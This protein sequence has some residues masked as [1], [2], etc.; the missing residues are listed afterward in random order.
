VLL[1]WRRDPHP[2]HRATWGPVS[3]AAPAARRLGYA[4]WLAERGAVGDWPAPTEAK[5][6]TFG[7]GAARECKAQAIQAHQTQLGA[8]SDDPSGF[9]LAPEMV[10]RALGGPELYFGPLA[11][12]YMP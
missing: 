3:A 10:E 2:D 12:G 6:W 9:V 8:L 11:P 5:V 1:P 7:V 4:V